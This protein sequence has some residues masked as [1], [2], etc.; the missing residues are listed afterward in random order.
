MKIYVGTLHT[1]ENEFAECVAAIRRQSHQN[2]DHFVFS[3]LGNVESHSALFGDFLAKRDDFDLLVKVD[4]D[5]VLADDHLFEAIE[6]RFTN[7]EISVF[8]IAV[9]DWFSDRLICGLATYRNN[10]QWNGDLAGVFVDNVSISIGRSE[11][12]FDRLAPAAYHCPN[13]SPFQA[14]HFGLH[15]AMKVIQTH[16][17]ARKN[18]RMRQHWDNIMKTESHFHQ[19][20]DRRLGLAIL[21][22][23]LVYTGLFRPEH[24]TYDHPFL[25]QVFAEYENKGTGEIIREIQRL[26]RRSA[27]WLPEHMRQAW[28]WYRFRQK[29]FSLHALYSLALGCI[30]RR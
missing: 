9:H 4:A 25:R 28:L 17:A 5:M 2:F 6:E 11:Y 12:D 21:A 20:G 19:S 24:I 23:E 18:W 29:Y 16:N 3:G 27:G 14:F 26:R 10:I 22:S 30:K 13:P 1:I 15:K 7:K 8:T